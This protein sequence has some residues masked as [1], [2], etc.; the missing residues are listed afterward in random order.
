MT[1]S[2]ALPVPDTRSGTLAG[3]G[4]MVLGIFLFSIND[5]MGK[6][7]VATYSVGQV[8]LLRSMAALLVL[9]PV[10]WRNGLSLK[11]PARRGLHVL[12]IA[13]STLDVAC[14]Y[15]AVAYLPLADVMTYYLAAPIYVAAFAVVW[16]GESLDRRR[17][18]AIAV[19][20]V[21]VLIALRPS[22]ATLTLPAIIALAGSVFFAL[23]M[24][25]T[26][27][28]KDASDTTLVLGQTLGALLVGCVAAPFAWVPP[29]PRDI[30]P[31]SPRHCRHG[32]PCLRQSVAEACAGFDRRALPVHAH[33]L[34]G[35]AG[36]SR[37]RRHRSDDDA[38]WRSRDLR[39]GPRPASPGA[40]HG[41]D[42]KAGGRRYRAADPARSLNHH[43]ARHRPSRALSR[44]W[45][46]TAAISP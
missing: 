38:H 7:L 18:A 42:T 26:R 8:L 9:L 23:L 10:V 46:S 17:V 6:W 34:G 3:I 35:R 28:L 21:G 22:G 29:T 41:A 37:V 44:L 15:G 33:R 12:R 5:V 2:R 19:G 27:K 1:V 25:T 20:F 11:M 32:R 40:R 31:V 24:I 14:F 43:V 4:L 45:M 16:L 30:A 13:C 39:R 36:L